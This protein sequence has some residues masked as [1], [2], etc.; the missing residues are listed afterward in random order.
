MGL[1]GG[2]GVRARALFS[3]A[4]IEW[5]TPPD[6]KM[7]LQK[8]FRFTLDPCLPGQIEDGREMSWKGHR[9]FCNPPYGRGMDKWLIKSKE[10]D[11]S[12]FLLPSRTDTSWF[13]DYCLNA[14]E[15]RFFRG[16]LKFVEGHVLKPDK[17]FGTAPFPSMLVIYL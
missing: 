7:A 11:L 8:E 1:E 5:G 15:I 9:V 17:F 6:L 4:H 14:S 16:R 2:R 3:S 10:A 13:H 12:V